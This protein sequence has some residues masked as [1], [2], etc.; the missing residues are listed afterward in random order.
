MNKADSER[1][2]S[3]LNQ[4][5]LVSTES[6]ESADIVV[7]NTC[8]VRQN[9]EDK[10]VGTLTSLKPSKELN[11]EKIIALI[12]SFKSALGVTI[13]ALFPPNSIISLPNR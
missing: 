12:A 7:L 6:K 5:G 2:S 1:L 4:M 9:A 13:I 11:P 3:A 8:V 10:A